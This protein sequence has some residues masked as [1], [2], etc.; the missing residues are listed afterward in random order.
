MRPYNPYSC[1]KCE[2]YE[3][4]REEGFGLHQTAG[5]KLFCKAGPK[6]EQLDYDPKKSNSL[7]NP[8]PP[9][10]DYELQARR[11]K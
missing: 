5:W 4:R 8:P 3:F 11:V 9:C 2:H 7:L 6:P 10:P 1:P